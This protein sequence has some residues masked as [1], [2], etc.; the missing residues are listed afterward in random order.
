VELI[1]DRRFVLDPVGYCERPDLAEAGVDAR[2]FEFDLAAAMPGYAPSELVV[3]PKAKLHPL[4]GGYLRL[5]PLKPFQYVGSN[6][7]AREHNER[8]LAGAT[9]GVC[10]FTS[11]SGGTWLTDMIASHQRAY[12]FAEPISA[13][14]RQ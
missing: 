10:L 2:G 8:L 1:V 5:G 12:A 13:C 7:K 11:R 14:R 9:R 4:P 3:R 6:A